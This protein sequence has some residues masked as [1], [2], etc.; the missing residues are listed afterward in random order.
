[1]N[2]EEIQ[3]PRHWWLSCSLHTCYARTN[4]EDI[5]DGMSG[6]LSKY[7]LGQHIRELRQFMSGIGGFLF[8]E[9]ED[10]RGTK[11]NT[12]SWT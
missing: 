11:G 5:I 4:E 3:Y 9:F 10:V 8:K 12:V 6:F 2:N 7:F 1:M